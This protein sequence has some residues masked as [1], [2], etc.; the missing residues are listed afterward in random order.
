VNLKVI[1]SDSR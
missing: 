1:L